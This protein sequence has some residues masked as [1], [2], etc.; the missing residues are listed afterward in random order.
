[1]NVLR[2]T[3]IAILALAFLLALAPEKA[4]AA[5]KSKVNLNSA[6][7]AELEALPGVGATTARKIIGGRPYRS[8]GDLSKAGVSESTI[9]KI[10]GLVTVGRG[11]PA[12]APAPVREARPRADAPESRPKADVSRGSRATP[13]GSS[14][15]SAGLVDLNRA[16]EKELEAL[17]GVGNVTARKIIAGRP[18]SSVGDL[19]S[20]G[21]SASTI[22][23]ISP[24]VTVSAASGARS[25]RPAPAPA[26]PS[27]P[28]SAS[29]NAPAPAPASRGSD[30]PAAQRGAPS[31]SPSSEY[32][33]PPSSGMVWV[34]LDSKI[35]H[36]EGD[37]WYGRTKHGKYMSEADALN[38]GYRL[39]R[40]KGEPGPPR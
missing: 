2:K 24:L 23:K 11:S 21:V 18:Y 32:Q 9:Q 36:R 33:A 5:S 12:P 4:A 3:P 10:S 20:A 29:S 31:S 6:S 38:A 40:E 34:N 39:S 37:R 35:F 8:V 7:Q 28:S 22:S 19:S 15:S 27:A 1:M 30:A 14:S 13:G 25:S 26:R 17:P 16:S